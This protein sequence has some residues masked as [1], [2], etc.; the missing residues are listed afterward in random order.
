MDALRARVAQP[1]PVLREHAQ[2]FFSADRVAHLHQICGEV[3]TLQATS[4][5]GVRSVDTQKST[6][7]ADI[8]DR[9]SPTQDGTMSFSAQYLGTPAGT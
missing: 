2:F 5:F 6:S 4:G 3:E 1:R 7:G 9:F 8:F